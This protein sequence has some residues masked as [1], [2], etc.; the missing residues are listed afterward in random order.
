MEKKIHLTFDKAVTR[1]AGY[2]YGKKVFKEQ[3]AS[4]VDLVNNTIYIVFP[5]EIVK[6]AS[7]FVQ[8]FFSDIIEQIG[9]GAIGKTVIIQSPNAD[10][11]DSVMNN[12]I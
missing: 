9:Y 3:I 11:K 12:L 5:K 4:E 10:F 7:S 1:L 8:G 6:A 2:E